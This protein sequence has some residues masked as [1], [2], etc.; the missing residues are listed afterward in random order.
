[1]GGTE[2]IAIWSTSADPAGIYIWNGRNGLPP[3]NWETPLARK[4]R[5]TH[6]GTLA[7]V[8]MDGTLEI[9]MSGTE[10]TETEPDTIFTVGLW[11][12]RN[13]QEDLPGW[14]VYMEDLD[15]WIGTSP[16][17]VDIDN[18][19]SKEIVITYFNF[20][21]ARVY[22]FNSDGTPYFE[23]PAL[24]YGVLLRT[25]TSLG[26][27]IVADIDG[28]GNPNLISRGGYIF[29]GTGYE[30]IFVWE[31]NG[32]PTPGFP[33][34]TPTPISEVVSSPF[35]PVV[36]D[37]DNDGMVELIMCCS[38]GILKLLIIRIECPGPNMRGMQKTVA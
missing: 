21:I 16:V 30:R 1:M 22:A 7:D 34:V 35:T 13:G 25:S 28:D 11:V 26:N 14:P 10:I 15:G 9:I 36:D 6:G 17:C 31:P 29:P 24:P 19:G 12:T 37:L 32:D 27:I 4:A 23:N 18:N 8:D 2:V 5:L 38:F 33:V 20:D 3:F